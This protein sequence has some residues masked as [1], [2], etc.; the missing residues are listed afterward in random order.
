MLDVTIGGCSQ[1]SRWRASLVEAVRSASPLPAPPDH[2]VFRRSVALAF[3]SAA[4]VPGGS[5]QGFEPETLTA[6]TVPGTLSAPDGGGPASAA[7]DYLDQLR[8]LREGRPGNVDLR[9]GPSQRT[10]LPAAPDL[11]P[12]QEES[13]AEEGPPTAH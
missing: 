2:R 1:D 11:P 8:A 12:P 4:F 6:M 7:P 3:A 5:T 13:A 10:D 9:I